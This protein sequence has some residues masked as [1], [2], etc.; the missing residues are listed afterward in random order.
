MEEHGGLCGSGRPSIVVRGDGVEELGAHLGLEAGS[1]LVDQPHAQVDMA[2][3]GTLDRRPVERAAVELDRSA[4]VVEDR[5][6]DEEVPPKAAV[7]LGCLA[8]EG[9]DGDGVLEEPARVAVVGVGCR[10]E[11]AEARA[12]R[13][14]VDE[15]GD[16][17]LQPGVRELAGEELEEAVQLVEVAP[18]LG[19]ELRRLDGRGLD[20][21]DV[22]LKAVPE[23]LD[24]GEDAHRVAFPE[25]RVEELD[26][27][28]DAALDASR[29]VHELDREIRAP[30]AGAQA[31][32]AGDGV[33]AF[34]D[35]VLDEL[36]DR[37]VRL[38]SPSR[39]GGGGAHTCRV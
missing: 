29:R 14:V 39:V 20:G 31:A 28:P 35:P 7:E 2:E 30:R 19:N 4:R 34:N 38:G 5:S 27:A 32:L 16:D 21:A 37:D 33:R 13:R 36:G 22:Q 9:R 12:E 23:A 6:G 15:P 25:A 3:E 11:V 8:A 17:R 24:A 26:V 1:A 10:G 18:R